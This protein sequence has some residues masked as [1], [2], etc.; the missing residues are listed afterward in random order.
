MKQL[1]QWPAPRAEK[2][3]TALLHDAPDCRIV[4]FTLAPN[5]EVAVHSSASSVI[6]HVVAGSGTFQGGSETLELHVGESAAYVPNEPHGMQAGADGLRFM[7]V[8]APSPS[9]AVKLNG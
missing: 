2:H 6:V 5:Q 9:K 4:A 7:A 1:E 3:A 8:I